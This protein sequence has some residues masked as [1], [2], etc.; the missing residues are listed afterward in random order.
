MTATAQDLV[1]RAR[2][3]LSSS[4][5]DRNRM[6]CWLARTALEAAVDDLLAARD[7][8]AGRANM[9]SRLTC[10]QAAYEGTD[11]PA[12]VEYAWSRLSEACH[13]HAY[14]LSPT[15]AETAH[16]IATVDAMIGAH[17]DQRK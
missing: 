16:L 10:L 2:A 6:A 13:Q 9:R 14:K 8:D 15:F 11:V 7:L 4:H 1:G 5:T 12:R 17:V 3:T